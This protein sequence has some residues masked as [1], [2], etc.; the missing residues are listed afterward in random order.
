[1]TMPLRKIPLEAVDLQDL[2]LVITYGPH[3]GPL[4]NSIARVGILH[5]P[6]LQEIPRSG[7]YR[8]VS[9]YKRLRAAEA[10][11]IKSITAHLAPGGDDVGLFLLGLHENLGTRPLNIVEKSLAL[12]KLA[13]QFRLSREEIL[14]DHLPA[15]GLGSDPKT[16]DLYLSLSGLEDEIKEELATGHLSLST[17]DQLSNLSPADRLAYCHL[18]TALGLGKNLQREFLTL[19]ADLSRIQKTTMSA[20][21]TG[22]EIKSLAQN[23]K[24]QAPVRAQRIRELLIRRR[25]PR[26]S[27]AADEFHKLKKKLKLPPHLSLTASPFFE[28]RDYRLTVVFRSR[29]QLAAVRKALDDMAD[30]PLLAELLE[31]T[32]RSGE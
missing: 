7:R 22:D 2:T 21:L 25:Y 1:M 4:K 16:L 3:L 19:L 18:V 30:N 17:A 13:D 29:E 28:G 14:T 8:I 31:L 9:G 10:L 6:I 11:G 5:P 20:L 32:V 15:L 26:L 23:P 12:N 27:R 24:V